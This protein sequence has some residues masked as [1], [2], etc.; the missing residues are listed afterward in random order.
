MTKN[1]YNPK[2]T[3]LTGN[4]G[5]SQRLRIRLRD[6]YTCCKC[7][8]ITPTGEVDHIIALDDNGTNDDDNLQYL[9]IECHKLKTATD[10]QY[11]IK[12]GS[13][14]DGLPTNPNHFWNI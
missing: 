5:V 8:R 1:K 14:V 7:K 11:T 12:T 9:C 4:A 6:N 13:T 2:H 10:R 3:R